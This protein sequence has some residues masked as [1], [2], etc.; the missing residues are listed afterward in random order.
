MVDVLSPEAIMVQEHWLSPCNLDKLNDISRDHI[1][2]GS[3]G[4]GAVRGA[5]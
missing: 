2:H 5:G 3:S 1:S 4:M